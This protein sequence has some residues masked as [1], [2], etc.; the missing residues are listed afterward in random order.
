MTTTSLLWIQ[1]IVA[2]GIIVVVAHFMA[3][4]ADVIAEKTGLG[5]SFVG[6]VMLAT[7]TSLPE[8]GLG[9]S[10]IV[11]VGEADLAA[12][13][14][15][16]SNLFNLLIIGIL[17]L[18]WRRGSILSSVPPTSALVGTLGVVVISVA[19]GAMLIHNL[20]ASM[21]HWYMS[22]ISFALFGTFLVSMFVIYK[23]Q[24]QENEATPESTE[25]ENY[26]D[27]SLSWAFATY[28][29]TAAIVVIAAVWLANV[30]E[31]VAIA[32]NW[33][34][35]FVG[36]QFLALSTSLPELAASIAALR[37]GAP[38]LAITNVLGSN[39]FNMGFVL[40]WDDVAFV[41]GALWSEISHIHQLTAV[42]AILMSAIVCVGIMTGKRRKPK[43]PISIEGAAMI[44]LYLVASI[45][46]FSLA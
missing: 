31:D 3:G 34:A 9:V 1:L 20:T 16:G 7:A 42:I 6:V 35:S 33:E 43:W 44:L 10:S 38:E 5:R 26:A 24:S 2:G 29:I 28:F 45:L 37:L 4:A 23:N 12:G 36:T 18:Y 39:L 25:G 46:V 21:S 41:E 17:D 22:P 8:L 15:F 32:M 27:K 14:A 19:L 30:G 13:D 11:L 40:F